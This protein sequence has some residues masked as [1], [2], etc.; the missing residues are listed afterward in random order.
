MASLRRREQPGALLVLDLDNFKDINDH[1]HAC[2]DQVLH[3]IAAILRSRVRSSDT[4]GRL[5]GD[6]FATAPRRRPQ[7]GARNVAETSCVKPCARTASP[8]K[9]GVYG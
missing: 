6:E 8:S 5:G 3:E 1:G 9:G 4:V 7:R 2:G